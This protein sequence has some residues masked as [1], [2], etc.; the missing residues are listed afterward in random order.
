M[1][2]L[3]GA[4]ELFGNLA[5]DNLFYA[6]YLAGDVLAYELLHFLPVGSG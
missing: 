4:D 3:P 6:H 1:S 2:R 5:A